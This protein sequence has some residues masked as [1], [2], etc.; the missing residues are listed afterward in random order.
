MYVDS[1]AEWRMLAGVMQQP[2]YVNRIM[3]TLFTDERVAVFEAMQNAYS[4]YGTVTYEGVRLFLGGKVPGELSADVSDNL[5]AIIDDLA[6][7]ARRR[8]LF[9][10]SN[11][12]KLE[13]AEYRPN[14]DSV[15]HAL[16]F[17]P[18]VPGADSSLVYGAQRLLTDLA[19][20]RTGNYKFTHTGFKYLDSMMG[21]EWQPQTLVI[22]MAGAGVGKTT[23]VCN[24]M[25]RMARGGTASLFYSLEMSKDKLLTRWLADSL[26]I[27]A[28]D[29]LNGTKL[30]DAQLAA[31][32]QETIKLQQLPM[33]VIDRGDITLDEI[34]QGIRQDVVNK[35]VRVV[36]VDY[37]QIVNHDAYG[38]NT[39]KNLGD[40][41]KKL[42][43]LA[44]ALGITIVV[45]CQKNRNGEGMDAARDS[46][47]I[48]TNADAFL[49]LEPHE[50]TPDEL[51]T[52]AVDMVFLKNRLG[53]LGR[54]TLLFNGKYQRFGE[55]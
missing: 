11:V 39:N 41:A 42:K 55:V 18:I 48:Q 25:L 27:D 28:R 34:M 7:I 15:R 49:E 6:L 20:K 17:A 50:D 31:I 54:N 21:G 43:R 24:S 30:T 51:G 16:D 33:Y 53:P 1:V 23:L 37:I 8:Q 26:E 3:P 13:A 2:E 10:A 44:E 40:V 22:L 9:N 38:S 19:R 35:G 52:R 12:L 4:K 47:E 46:G 36:F 32:E 29:I 45:L 5:D 14:E